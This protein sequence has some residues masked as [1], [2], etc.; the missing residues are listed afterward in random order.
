MNAVKP[1][2]ILLGSAFALLVAC[3]SNTTNNNGGAS[4]GTSG[5]APV[6]TADCKSRC[7]TK[8][9]TCGAPAANATQACAQICDGRYTGDQLN[10][11]EATDCAKLQTPAG[12]EA[13][14][15]AAPAGTSG[16]TS[17]SGT[18]GT[19]G[20]STT[21]FSCSLNGTCYKCNDSAGVQKCSIQ[22]GPGPGC[23]QT[24]ASYCEK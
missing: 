20:T 17:G 19:S 12:F 22:T 13:A 23:T 5:S 24:D 10:C 2:F 4:G 11:L 18:S 1:I 8:A 6:A 9:T 16:G 14:C 15:P 21:Q 7:Q 3:T